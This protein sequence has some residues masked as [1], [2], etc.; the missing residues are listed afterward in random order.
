MSKIWD[1]W[2]PGV[3]SRTQLIKMCDKGYLSGFQRSRKEDVD[4][5]SIDLHLTDV[6][7]H[8]RRGSFKPFRD[9]GFLRELLKKSQARRVRRDKDGHFTLRPQR[10]YLFELREGLHFFDPEIVRHKI[11][12]AQA[13]AKSTIGRVDVL[14]RL[15]VEGM[16][17][18]ERFAPESID[19]ESDVAPKKMYVEITPISFPVRVKEGLAITQLRLFLGRPEDCLIPR[20]TDIVR[21]CFADPDLHNEA[22]LSVDLT[23]TSIAGV[24]A[25][26][27]CAKGDPRKLMPIPLWTTSK[28][29]HDPSKWWGIVQP[30]DGTCEIG[31]NRFHILRS[32]E[33]LTLPPGVAVYARASDEE[34]GEMRIHYAGFVHPNFGTVRADKKKG[35]P[36]IFEV[37]CHN[38]RVILRNGEI[39]ARLQFYRMSQDEKLSAYDKEKIK[40][41]GSDPYS[42]QELNLSKIFSRQ[43]GS[44]PIVYGANHG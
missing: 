24:D 20:G 33:R 4:H 31:V 26:G 2:V 30:T 19:G 39:L 36:L 28:D 22:T 8:L 42:T 23:P 44:R 41:A 40:K 3:L 6:G 21:A 37:R 5:S 10:T 25:C 13:T 14:A 43:W 35:T 38:L 9:S 15:V 11:F 16:D 27:Y 12:Y 34:I 7:Y 17:H 1:D 29:G 18:Y 32:R